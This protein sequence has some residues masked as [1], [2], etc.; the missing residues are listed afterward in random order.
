MKLRT[1][2]TLFLGL[3]LLACASVPASQGF[4]VGWGENVSGEATGTPS[5][6]LSNGVVVMPGNPNATNVVTIHG[7]ELADATAISAGRGMSLAIRSDGAVVGWGNNWLGRVIGKESAYA[8]RTNGPVEVA[9]HVLS[10]VVSIAVGG[11]FGLGLKRDGTVTTWGDNTVPPGL[12]DVVG[13]AAGEYYNFVVKRDGTLVGWTS[14]PLNPQRGQLFAVAEL[15]NIVSVAVGGEG[16]VSRRAAL[17]KNGTVVTWGS[18]TIYDDATP[19]G[20]LSN[21]IAISAGYNHTLALKNDGTV[22]GWGYNSGGQATGV[23]TKDQPYVAK[24]PV[25]INGRILD[26]VTAIAAGREYSL[27]LKKDGTVVAWGDHRFY[28]DVPAGLSNVVAIAAGDGFC[29]AITTNKSVAD[30]IGPR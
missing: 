8:H 18:Q 15:S 9:G 25:T 20:G 12:H 5:Y 19:L 14:D 24:G 28:R 23:A 7:V 30:K 2:R 29:L 22:V 6:P 16:N 1:I 13:I 3:P 11:N 10:N 17:K 26:G 27:A 4:V 21:V